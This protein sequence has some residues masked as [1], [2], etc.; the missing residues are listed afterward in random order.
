VVLFRCLLA[1]TSEKNVYKMNDVK[2][3]YMAFLS[4]MHLK[5]SFNDS[6]Y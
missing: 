3:V 5:V 4:D 6:K 2:S 1:R